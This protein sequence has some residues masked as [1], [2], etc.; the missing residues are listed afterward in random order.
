MFTDL[1]ISGY[2]LV[3]LNAPSILPLRNVSVPEPQL[4]AKSVLVF[5]IKRDK[6]LFEKD[7]SRELPMAS[8]TKLLSSLV[9]LDALPLEKII[10]VEQKAVDTP[11]D[12]GDFRAGEQVEARHLFFASLIQSSND[13]LMAL[14]YDL[15]LENFMS[16]LRSKAI[17][18]RLK[19]FSLAD[20]VGLSPQTS[21]TGF[22]LLKVVRAAFSNE[23]ITQVLAIPEYTF[24]SASGRVHRAISTNDLIFNHRVIAA[25]TGSLKEAGENYAAL[26]KGA[27]E[28]DKFIIIILGSTNRTKDVLAL[29]NW[30]D[31][32][33]VWR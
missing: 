15:G 33:F 13:A 17:Q 16:L 1:I 29:L 19:K 31:K 4:L 22:E 21:T 3:A 28:E 2:M 26:V 7:S 11:G 24:K 14:V 27:A 8:L 18:L 10:T 25:K 6:V 30:L 5:D 32:G 12:A 9:V 20:P 23:F